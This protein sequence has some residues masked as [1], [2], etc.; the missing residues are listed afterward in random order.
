[1][2]MTLMVVSD[3]DYGDDGG[4]V[5]GDQPGEVHADPGG[6]QLEEAPG[7]EDGAAGRR[8]GPAHRHPGQGL[9]S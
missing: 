4:D 1:M 6:D 8:L 7:G 2:R 9:Q 5:G 3:G